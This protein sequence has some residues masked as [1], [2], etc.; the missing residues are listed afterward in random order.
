MCPV[1]KG[2]FLKTSIQIFLRLPYIGHENQTGT[3]FGLALQTNNNDHHRTS[4]TETEEYL[5]KWLFERSVHTICKDMFLVVNSLLLNV[6]HDTSV[7]T[8]K[9]ILDQYVLK[10][11]YI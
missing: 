4:R 3:C 1:K 11:N 7:N 2:Y 9:S 8:L 10:S 5:V 6:V